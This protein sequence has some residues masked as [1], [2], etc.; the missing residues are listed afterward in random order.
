MNNVN[1]IGRLTKDVEVRKTSTNKSVSSF[2]I[3]VDNLATKDGEKTT[4]FFN[5]N[6]WNNVAET[7]SKYTRKGDRIAI[8]GSLIQ[9]NYEN[10]NGE[11]ISV[12]EINV[13]SITL[14]ENKKENASVNSE[15]KAVE[16][17]NKINDDDLPF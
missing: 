4:S 2:S 15:N 7:L 5:C 8:S 9:R 12:V 14:I 1:I 6:A 17:D 16:N 3:A 11:K 10:K 13:N